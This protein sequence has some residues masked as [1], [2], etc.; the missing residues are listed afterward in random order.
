MK[1]HCFQDLPDGYEKT[2]ALDLQNDSKLALLINGLALAI[3]A[4]MLIVGF[5]LRSSSA[6]GMGLPSLAAFLVSLVAYM[7]LH[8]LVHGACMKLFGV[9]RVRFGF[10]GLY[11]FAGSDEYLKK[12][13][14]IVVALA[15]LVVWGVVLLAMNLLGGARYFFFFYLLQVIN[16]SGAAGDLY[17]TFRLLPLPNGILV[18]DTGVAM[19]VYAPQ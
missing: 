10:T 16:V 2:L 11:A 9:Q 18:Q 12:R 15:P 14:Y 3:A 13:E 4:V 7:V 5:F 19:T 8:E 6:F 1:K 17:V